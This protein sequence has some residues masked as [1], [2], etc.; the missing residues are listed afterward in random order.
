MSAGCSFDDDPSITDDDIVW[1][2]VA[3]IFQ[4]RDAAGKLTEIQSGAFA[5]SSDGTPMSVDLASV[6]GDVRVTAASD[7]GC[8]VVAL[9]VGDLRA[10]GLKVCRAPIGPNDP[11]GHAENP[12]H[13]Y[14]VGHKG[15]SIRRKIRALASVEHEGT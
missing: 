12:A 3:R 15:K 14:V 11:S 6:A 9:S 13:A 2:R 8:V 1:R 5:D 10:L 4:E 7:A